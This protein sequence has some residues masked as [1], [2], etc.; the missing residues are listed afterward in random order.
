MKK[1][2]VLLTFI[3]P[4]AAYAQSYTLIAEKDSKTFLFKTGKAA[5]LVYVDGEVSKTFR[6]RLLSVR[7]A[8]IVMQSFNH[9]D[10]I[11]VPLNTITSMKRIARTGRAITGTIAGISIVS[12]VAMIADDMS[13]RDELFDGL[14]AG[15]GVTLMILL[16]IPY[17]IVTLS[18]PQAKTAKG[19]IFKSIPDRR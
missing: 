4:F 5:K 10:S 12:G 1:Y 11:V 13:T 9:K 15:A 16:S 19:F 17:A 3:L 7:P 6:G 14:E 8:A 2:L 18:E